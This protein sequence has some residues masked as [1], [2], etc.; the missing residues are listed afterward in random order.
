MLF[1]PEWTASGHDKFVMMGFKS[2]S[3]S[4]QNEPSSIGGDA[5]GSGSG[6]GLHG[7]PAVLGRASF[8]GR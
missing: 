4:I 2:F 8:Q 6:K 3:S 7:Y 1:W 5:P